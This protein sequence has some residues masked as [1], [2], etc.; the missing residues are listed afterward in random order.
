MKNG[1][2]SRREKKKLFL[3]LFSVKNQLCPWEMSENTLAEKTQ[4]FMVALGC[5]LSTEKKWNFLTKDSRM[6]LKTFKSLS[7]RLGPL[8]KGRGREIGG[9]E[10][11][12]LQ[13]DEG[14]CML[15]PL[16]IRNAALRPGC[17]LPC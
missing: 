6:L 9:L 4:V 8:C 15:Q 12:K 16:L 17:F 7:H 11:V 3:E 2:L 1:R 10:N 5:C 14:L 13:P